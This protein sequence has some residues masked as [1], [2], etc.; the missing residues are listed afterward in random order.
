MR[1]FV[2]TT[3]AEGKQFLKDNWEKGCK[4]PL[5]TQNVK[6]FRRKLN[7]G[8]ARC[9]IAMLKVESLGR[10][11]ADGWMHVNHELT[12]LGLS[13]T[14]LEAGKLAGWGFME[15]RGDQGERSK[16]SGYWR[17]TEKGR[18][19][20]RRQITVPDHVYVFN[21]TYYGVDGPEID[22]VAALGNHFDYAEMMAGL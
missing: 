1:R 13:A 10:C 21:G 3:I 19:F 7:S 15:A 14:D 5:C 11:D 18:A 8:M 20:A 12:K 4:C 22:I 16:T 9:L 2:G 17:L 6:K